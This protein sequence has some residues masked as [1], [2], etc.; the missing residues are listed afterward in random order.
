MTTLQNKLALTEALHF[1]PKLSKA[2]QDQIL[3]RDLS[4]IRHPKSDEMGDFAGIWVRKMFYEKAATVYEG[5]KHNHDHLSLLANGRVIIEVEGYEP[6]EFIAPTFVIIR[7]N[8][9]HKITAMEDGTTWFC[10][11]N[12][13][14]DGMHI[15]SKEN[16]PMSDKI[17]I[18]FK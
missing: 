3:C 15:Y 5:H 17:K 2:E 8:K 14:P 11:F 10:L 4:N 7:K 9:E 12:H 6:K 1:N 13:D 16:N 18:D